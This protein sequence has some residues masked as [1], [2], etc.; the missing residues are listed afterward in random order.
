MAQQG[1]TESL[2][3]IDFVNGGSDLQK[4]FPCED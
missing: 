4:L 2:P 3:R 1:E